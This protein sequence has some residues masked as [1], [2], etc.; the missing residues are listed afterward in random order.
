MTRCWKNVAQIFQK[1]PK[2][3]DSTVLLTKFVFKVTP[4][5][6]KIFLDSFCKKI[7]CLEVLKNGQSGHTGHSLL[8]T[9]KNKIEDSIPLH[10][11]VFVVLVVVHFKASETLF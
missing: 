7:C 10:S 11:I 4:K 1:V 2:I 3:V 5:S 9:K 8:L 6:R